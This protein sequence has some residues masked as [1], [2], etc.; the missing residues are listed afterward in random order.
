MNE[1]S[2]GACTSRIKNKFEEREKLK[3]LVGP[4]KREVR[5]KKERV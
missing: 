3:F 1:I 2:T 4:T 5:K